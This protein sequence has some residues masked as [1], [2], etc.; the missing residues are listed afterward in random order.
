MHTDVAAIKSRVLLS[1]LVRPLVGLKRA[2]NGFIGLCPFHTEKTPSFHVSDLR[3]TYKCFGCG[4]WGDAIDWVMQ[5]HSVGFVEAIQVLEGR[6]VVLSKG[7]IR[8]VVTCFGNLDDSIKD[9][10]RRIKHAHELWLKR[11]PIE[12][13]FAE[14]YLH[15]A[16]GISTRSPDI[17]GYVPD[18]Y[19]SLTSSP[20]PAL[21]A[22]LQDS[23]GHVSA[24]QQ[25]FLSPHHPHDALRDEKG[26]RFKRTI[27]VMRDGAVRLAVSGPTLGLAGSVEDGLS[28]MALFSLPVWAVCGEA[29]LASVWIPDEVE[30][31]VIF[32]DSDDAGLAFAE[33][34]RKLYGRVRQADIVAPQGSKDWQEHLTKS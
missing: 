17:L 26:K 15:K 8:N 1:S 34:A 6:P 5:A 30:R 13:T 29:R 10:S 21:V 33:E 9:E 31:V 24:I 4:A 25:I 32:A 7:D 27:G 16:R 2:A 20:M 11:K 18:A 19:C 3:G 14:T 28:A 22:P 23:F 12:G